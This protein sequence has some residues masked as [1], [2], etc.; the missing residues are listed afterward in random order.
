MNS[1]LEVLNRFESVTTEVKALESKAET[2]K[3]QGAAL[4]VLEQGH[5]QAKK[6]EVTFLAAQ[7][8]R[9]RK[10]SIT[11][12][13]PGETRGT[14]HSLDTANIITGNESTDPRFKFAGLADFMRDPRNNGV[15][16]SLTEGSD[17]AHVLPGAEV[18]PFIRAY[19]NV[20]PLQQ[21]GAT[22][23]DV[24]GGWVDANIPIITSGV[25]PSTY[26][27]GAGPTNDEPASV[28]VAQLK[29][30]AKYAFL[31]K[32]TEEA[33]Q[34]IASLAQV[35]GQEGIRPVLNKIT[36]AVTQALCTQL[37]TSS[38]TV[39]HSGDNYEDMLNMIAA[40]PTMF[41]GPN[42]VWMGSRATKAL[43]R[44]TRAGADNLPVFN[45]EQTSL[46]GY[47]FVQN[48][49]VPS[50]KLLFGDFHNGVFLRRSAVIFQI[51]QEVYREAGKIGLRFYQRADWAF[52]AEAANA[53]ESEQPLY[54]LTSDF[55]S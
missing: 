52:F 41:A 31:C 33:M 55:G 9:L 25:E 13:L 1:Q 50:G 3:N 17:L 8:E 7:V 46:L 2:L 15:P 45:A 5:L 37:T 16:L 18:Q 27:E 49:Y 34:D 10:T 42:N 23:Q 48:D 11:G 4:S 14:V 28:Y 19:P 47:S 32:P 54:L 40:I 36:K 39:A 51:L 38:A 29:D 43:L 20:D 44:N 53:S 24:E 35:L 21:A 26:S 30:P 6:N 12:L 22:I